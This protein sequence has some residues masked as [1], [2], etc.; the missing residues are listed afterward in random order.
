MLLS[1]PYLRK[2]KAERLKGKRI[3]LIVV[4]DFSQLPPIVTA[5]DVKLLKKFGFDT[6]GFA[7]TTKEWEYKKKTTKPSTPAKTPT[8]SGPQKKKPAKATKTTKASAG[9]A[10]KKASAPTTRTKKVKTLRPDA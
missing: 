2:K 3:R 4:D 7:F 5:A 1:C 9:R 10:T 8:Q 6:S